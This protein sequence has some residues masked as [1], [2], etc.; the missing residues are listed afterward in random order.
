MELGFTVPSGALQHGRDLVV[1]EAFYIMK[2]EDHAIARRQG[3]DRTLQGDAI[4]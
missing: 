4:D 2:D 1:F 3:C